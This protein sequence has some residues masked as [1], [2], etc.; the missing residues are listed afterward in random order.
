MKQDILQQWLDMTLQDSANF[1]YDIK[2]ADLDDTFGWGEILELMWYQEPKPRFGGILLTGP[3]GCGK[4]TAA[5]HTVLAV[6]RARLGVVF[7]DGIDFG[8]EDFP[9]LQE[10]LNVLLDQ[11]YDQNQGLCLVME[12]L[13]DLPW[14]RELLTFLGRT[15]QDY[16]RGTEDPDVVFPPLFLV[17][18]DRQE[19]SIPS[20]LRNK[21][22]LCR[23]SL[24]NRTRREQ[25]LQKIGAN[26]RNLVSMDQF[27]HATEG[28]TYA[29]LK[30]MVE[31]VS[32][33][34]TCRDHQLSEA[35]FIRFLEEQMPVREEGQLAVLTKAVR[36]LIAQLP[37]V[38]QT[39]GQQVRTEQTVVV[40]SP[41]TTV[42]SA[43]ALPVD[44][45]YVQ[46][47]Q[48]EVE[49]L[50]VRDLSVQLFGEEGAAMLLNA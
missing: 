49:K 39:V 24:P 18:L 3:D 13:E 8:Q 27:A 12:N 11:F 41:L 35:E 22:R 19:E 31:N 43:S 34:I 47:R 50:S 1:E 17:L 29:Q 4:H 9:W 30:A 37:D 40:Q 6:R 46:K 16:I 32:A 2:R 38:I 23:M 33:L 26:L 21:L 36:D 42:A 20:V 48:Q 45:D 5:A 44:G 10:R 14:R 28:A 25:F 7:L 15:L